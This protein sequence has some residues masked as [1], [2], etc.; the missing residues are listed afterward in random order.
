M[1]RSTA[2]PAGHLVPVC[3]QGVPLGTQQRSDEKTIT[4]IT[5]TR[6][7][8]YSVCYQPQ[9]ATFQLALWKLNWSLPEDNRAKKCFW[10]YHF[11]VSIR[12]TVVWQN[13]FM[14]TADTVHPNWHCHN[15]LAMNA[16]ANYIPSLYGLFDGALF[17]KSVT[18]V[19]KRVNRGLAVI[20]LTWSVKV[21]RFW[22][23]WHSISRRSSLVVRRCSA[24]QV[25]HVVEAIV[26]C[27]EPR[28]LTWLLPHNNIFTWTAE[29]ENMFIN[30]LNILTQLIISINF[31]ADVC[32]WFR[33]NHMNFKHP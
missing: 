24:C 20:T 17:Y 5:S 3:A 15:L 6:T 22:I 18:V 21:T 14:P 13:I 30:G 28:W 31:Y 29:T 25:W 12:Y 33:W 7:L 32:L 23:F 9:T 16:N 4:Y 26:R 1:Y 2:L 27:A 11:Q 8:S 10:H 19:Q